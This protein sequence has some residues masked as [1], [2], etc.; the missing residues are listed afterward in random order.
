[1]ESLKGIL[2]AYINAKRNPDYADPE[3]G[4]AVCISCR[5]RGWNGSRQGLG[6]K[7]SG[8]L[9]RCPGC[10]PQPGPSL[11]LF[12]A[13]NDDLRKARTAAEKWAMGEG[14]GILVL[15]GPVGVGKTHLARAAFNRATTIAMMRGQ[16]KRWQWRTHS[17]LVAAIHHG[18]RD[19]DAMAALHAEWKE[20]RYYA[21][22]DV[23]VAVEGAA[24]K[25]LM[26]QFID[27]RWAGVERGLRTIITT[28]LG[29]DDQPAHGLRG[30]QDRRR[31]LLD[32]QKA[33]CQGPGNRR[34]RLPNVER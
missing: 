19:T 25:G 5:G 8:E 30:C 16:E 22:D 9:Y 11:A 12:D 31:A 15:T 28:N 23:G 26:D 24:T 20:V 27:S 29:P 3:E 34:R 6:R 1:M 4:T 18:F 17:E 13:Y 21:V 33:H 2:E 32:S 14:P 10:D 7:G